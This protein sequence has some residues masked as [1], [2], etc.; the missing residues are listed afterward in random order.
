MDL[1]QLLGS[2]ASIRATRLSADG[3]QGRLPL[4]EDM[5]LNEPSG[6][7]FGLTQNAGM[8][9]DPGE[10]NRPAYLILTTMGGLRGDDGRPIALGYHTG[11]WELGLL[12]RQAAETLRAEGALPF[13]AYVSDPC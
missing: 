1:E 11:H 2:A 6:S 10:V 3:P 13:A 12:A 8:G 5:L 4:T 9:W 7:L